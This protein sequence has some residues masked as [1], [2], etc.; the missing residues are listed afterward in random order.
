MTKEERRAEQQVY[1]EVMDNIYKI[2]RQIN[3]EKEGMTAEERVAY[4]HASVDEQ[5]RNLG[6]TRNQ[7]YA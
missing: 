7:Q 2:R 6:I 5:C 1:K 4:V 3:K